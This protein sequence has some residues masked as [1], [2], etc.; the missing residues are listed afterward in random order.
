MISEGFGDD[1]VSDG[2]MFGDDDA[3]RN[4]KYNEAIAWYSEA[5]VLGGCSSGESAYS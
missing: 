3:K 1:A 5:L 4:E 2:E